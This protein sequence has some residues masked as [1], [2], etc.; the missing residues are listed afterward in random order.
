MDLEYV[1]N[2]FFSFFYILIILRVFLTWLPNLDWETKPLK[3]LSALTDWYLN[4]FRFIPPIG[5]LDFSPVIALL[6][7][8]LFQNVI[9]SV[10]KLL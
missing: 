8:P 1:I 2:T 3:G 6:L 9:I 4:L 7:L 5:G 10:L